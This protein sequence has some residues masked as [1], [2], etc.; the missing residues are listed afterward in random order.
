VKFSTKIFPFVPGVPWKLKYHQYITPEIF[1]IE[2][3]KKVTTEKDFIVTSYGGL[4]ESFFSLSFLEFLNDLHPAAEKFWAG[5]PK[6]LPLVKCQNLA[7]YSEEPKS[8]DLFRFPTPVFLDASKFTIFN[9]LFNYIQVYNIYGELKYQ[10]GKAI[11]DQ[12]FKNSL[13]PWDSKYL[14]K[15]RANLSLTCENIL[16]SHNLSLSDDYVLIFPEAS[17][18]SSHKQSCLNWNVSQVKALASMLKQQ[19]LKTIVLSN[20]PRKYLDANVISLDFNLELII[21]LLYSCKLILSESIDFL[22]IGLLVSSAKLASKPTFKELKLE[23]NKKWLNHN[24]EIYNKENLTPI[25]VYYWF[26]QG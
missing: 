18:L 13:L 25:D 26:L 6:F 23:K 19:Q 12:I 20:N 11:F 1:P 17:A 2:L 5:D 3:W 8:G 24:N 15:I 14:P 9:S 4:I 22:L 7:N 21:N 10:D 16:R